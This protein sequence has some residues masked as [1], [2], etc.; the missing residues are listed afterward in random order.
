MYLELTSTRCIHLF[1]VLGDST[2]SPETRYLAFSSGVYLI[3]VPRLE[4]PSTLVWIQTSVFAHYQN[5]SD[6]VLDMPSTWSLEPMY[7][8]QGAL[9]LLTPGFDHFIS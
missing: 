3:H 4:E 2:T 6:F 1:N 9:S 5:L 7:V 8:V